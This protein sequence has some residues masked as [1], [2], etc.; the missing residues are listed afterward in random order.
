MKFSYHPLKDLR[1]RFRELIEITGGRDPVEYRTRLRQMMQMGLH[2]WI[3][4]D[5]YRIVGSIGFMTEPG[6]TG[7]TK[8]EA[9]KEAAIE[10]GIDPDTVQVRS[11]IYVHPDY[12]G[13][14]LADELEKRA[15]RTSLELGFKYRA[16]FAYDNEEIYKW[17]HRHGN[18]IDLLPE[19]PTGTGF[20]ATLVPLDNV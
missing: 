3:A 12:R 9:M 1:H 20:P 4:E 2:L 18:A 8:S 16:A 7:W 10:K 19:E 11:L 14:G 6:E 5:N 17:I 13:K 15:N